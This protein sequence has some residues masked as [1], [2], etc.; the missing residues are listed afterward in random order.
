M[1]E[2]LSIGQIINT[3]G[4]KGELKIYPLT[5]DIR[6]FRNLKRVFINNEE[7]KVIW[8]KLQ[9]DK[10]ILKIEGIDSIEDAIKYRNKYLEVPRAEAVKLP[11]GRYYIA[12]LIGCKVFDENEEEIGTLVD[13]IQT[14]SNDVYCVKGEKEVLVPVLK[15]IVVSIDIEEERIIIKPIKEWLAE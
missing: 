9:N 13:V 12:D 7:K 5:D 14:K 11:E 4:L 3:H 1:K 8:C 15:T 2:F 10:V 6:R